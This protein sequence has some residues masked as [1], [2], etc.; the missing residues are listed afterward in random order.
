VRPGRAADHSPPSSHG[1]VELY[2]YP[3]SGPHRACNG[4]TTFLLACYTGLFFLHVT[5][6][7]T[8]NNLSLKILCIF[9]LIHSSDMHSRFC[10]FNHN[11]CPLCLVTLMINRYFFFFPVVLRLNAGLSILIL[12]VC[13]SHNGSPQSVRLL[14]SSDQLVAETST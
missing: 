6:I 1:R 10:N 14:W 4:K 2:L 5:E 3:H 13:K 11:K 9:H 8:Q 12:E 7:L